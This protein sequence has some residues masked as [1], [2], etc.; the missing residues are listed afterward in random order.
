M[1]V[2]LLVRHGQAS[3]GAADYDVLSP[4]GEQQ[5]GLLGARLAPLA[6]TVRAVVSGGLVRQQDTAR[7]LAAAAGLGTAV[8]TDPGWDEYDA[9]DVLSGVP[10]RDVTDNASF[11]LLLDDALLRWTSGEADGSYGES[12]PAFRARVLAALDRALA[13]PGTT[14][15]TTSAGS[16][17]VAAAH[18]LGLPAPGWARLARVQ[19][20]SGLTKV[21]SGRSGTSLVSFN[22][23]AHL[24]GRAGLLT[25]R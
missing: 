1:S 4:R 11:Q 8:E 24:E 17:G 18:V 19:V 12:W 15:V 23:H 2:L 13:R 5:A 3:F 9:V 14:V 10:T 20:N 22:D 16:I 21:V 25:Y 7:H 6:P